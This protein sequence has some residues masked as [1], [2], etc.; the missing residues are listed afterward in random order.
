MNTEMRWKASISL[1]HWRSNTETRRN[2]QKNKFLQVQIKFST[3]KMEVYHFSLFRC[4][5]TIS[6]NL[7]K[8]RHTANLFLRSSNSKDLRRKEGKYKKENEKYTRKDLCIIY[9]DSET[10]FFRS[11]WDVRKCTFRTSFSSFNIHFTQKI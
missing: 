4:T 3:K 5:L 10:F 8:K 6:L 2:G 1:S 11:C 9:L 7:S